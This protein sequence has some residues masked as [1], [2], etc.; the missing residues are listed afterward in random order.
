MVVR[1]FAVVYETG[2]QEIRRLIDTSDD[3][4][5]SHLERV[6]KYLAPDETMEVFRQDDFPIK[7]PR[8]V[9]PFLGQ[10]AVID[11]TKIDTP[12]DTTKLADISVAAIAFAQQ[13]VGEKEIPSGPGMTP[14]QKALFQAMLL[15]MAAAVK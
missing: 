5:D 13:E 7:F 11:K 8:F 2:T 12:T 9:K 1:T 4:D 6:K 14:E 15:D 10:G 3:P